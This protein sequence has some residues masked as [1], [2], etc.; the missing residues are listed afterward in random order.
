VVLEV[1]EP[2]LLSTVQDAGRPGFA[3]LGV[4]V[5]G[6]C[7]PLGLAVANLLLGSPPGTPALEMTL[8]GPTLRAEE[9][10]VVAIAGADLE[11]RLD[12]APFP[13]GGSRLLRAGASLRFGPARRGARAYLALT[14]GISV[15][16]VLGSASTY[17]PARLGGIEG[18]ALQVGD[19]LVPGRRGDLGA[20]GRSWPTGASRQQVASHRLRLLP[21]P[22]P[23]AFAEGAFKVLLASEWRV[24]HRS[25][26]T[27]LRLTLPVDGEGGR[28]G[29]RTTALSS[30]RLAGEMVSQP[31]TWGAVQVPPDGEPIVLQA[32]HQT[33]GGYPVLAVV[34]RADRTILGQL[35]PGERVRLVPATIDDAQ[36]AYREQLAR[37]RRVAAQLDSQRSPA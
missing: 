11:A 3:Y 29:Q 30:G 13:P 36:R 10:C 5:S 14:G 22:H 33:I 24:H 28:A 9:D 21:G 6:A 27:G 20:A 31:M 8:A 16:P 23:E 18:R 34:I 37:L 19:R 32:D 35:A 2:G 15:P 12:G 25:D 4:P 17:L 26:R 7:D 1:L